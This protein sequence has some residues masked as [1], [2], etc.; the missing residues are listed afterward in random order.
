MS[1][2]V[3]S[4][5]KDVLD[6]ILILQS[7]EKTFREEL[8]FFR[9][10]ASQGYAST[11]Y[12]GA[13]KRLEHEVG[14]LCIDTYSLHQGIEKKRSLYSKVIKNNGKL[15]SKV[16]ETSR[17][18]KR[19]TF[20]YIFCSDGKREFTPEEQREFI[21]RSE[22]R[23]YK[24]RKESRDNSGITSCKHEDLDEWVDQI[25]NDTTL[26]QL[27][28]YR[29]EFAHRLDS[30]DNLKRELQ[31]ESLNERIKEIL[32]TISVVLVKYNKSL[33]NILG[34]TKSQHCLGIP[35]FEYDSLSRLKLWD[36]CSHSK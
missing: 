31:F 28:Q 8:D 25:Q 17:D 34:Y 21:E 15:L 3:F 30:L 9:K 12:M 26:S 27:D 33:N 7:R 1:E 10:E 19:Y 36:S 13:L 35:G 20:S 16:D 23:A 24:A 6:V 18:I 5:I 4:T 11:L 2:E 14:C 22:E 32:D 29:N